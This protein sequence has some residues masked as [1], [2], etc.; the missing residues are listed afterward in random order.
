LLQGAQ[1]V[2]HC[3]FSEKAEGQTGQFYRDCKFYQSKANLDPEIAKKL[4][5]VS[6]KLVGL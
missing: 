4:W 6:E 3:A 5:D 1:G 2:A